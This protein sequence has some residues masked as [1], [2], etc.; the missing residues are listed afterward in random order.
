MTDYETGEPEE[1]PDDE[2]GFPVSATSRSLLERYKISPQ[3]QSSQPFT[4][5]PAHT[6]DDG[7]LDTPVRESIARD[8]ESA[9][10]RIEA[11]MAHVTQE[12]TEG[13]IN[14]AQF[15]ALY[16]HYAERKTLILRLLARDPR[17]DAWQRVASEGYTSIL[18]RR[19][20]ARLEGLAL[21]DNWSG[22]LLRALGEVDIPRNVIRP[23]L[24]AIRNPT[25]AP[26][27]AGRP[28]STQIEGGRWLSYYRGT[29]VTE[30]A[31]YSA[32]PSAVQL[33]EQA[34]L[35]DA[36]EDENRHRLEAGYP[37]ADALSYPQ[38]ALF[39][40]EAPPATA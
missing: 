24:A 6:I 29:F 8:P 37:D 18:R 12:L 5:D 1:T 36:F 28:L 26:A 40:G 16:T 15:Q 30:I 14:Q 21:L 27:E 3:Q 2:V 34:A 32:E 10:Q 31:V 23:L 35:H 33:I 9:L 20:A 7:E 39:P 38:A 11:K 22:Q 13:R 25:S 4:S 19:H 17:T